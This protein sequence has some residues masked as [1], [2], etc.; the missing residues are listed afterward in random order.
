MPTFAAARAHNALKSL[1]S[2]QALVVGGTAGIG[3][4][5]AL[6]L[7]ALGA[8]VAIGGRNAEQGRLTVERLRRLNPS[9]QHAFHAV[10]TSLTTTVT[11]FTRDFAATHARLD[12]LVVSAGML[13]LQGRT[14]TREGFDAKMAVHYYGR[15][16]LIRGLL[17]L[18]ERTAAMPGQTAPPRVLSIL[19]AGKGGR[20]DETDMELKTTYSLK[21]AADMASTYNDLMTDVAPKTGRC[22]SRTE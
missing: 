12:V 11:A 20:I 21:R 8:S 14:E 13:T 9:G 3:Q 22:H 4:A 17:S 10:D 15:W 2:R 1:V 5:T 16:T 7:A 18:L 19:A 6:R